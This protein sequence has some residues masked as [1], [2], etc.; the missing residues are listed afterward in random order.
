[1][2]RKPT[3]GGRRPNAGRPAIYT[4]RAKISIVLESS[5]AR[6]VAAEARRRKTSRSQLVAAAIEAERANCR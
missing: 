1:M 4:D 6:W 3:H 5:L 2:T